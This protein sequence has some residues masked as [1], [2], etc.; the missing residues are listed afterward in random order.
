MEKYGQYR[1]KGSGI[2]PFFPISTERSGLYLPFHV[3]LF[4]IRVPLLIAVTVT[5][6]LLFSWLPVN[7]LVK[8]AA[9]WTIL[10]I[11]G[12]W[13]VDLQIDGVKRG[14][15][16]KHQNRLPRAGSL[17]A[18]SFT[19][20]VDCLYLAAIFDPVFTASYPSTRLVERISLFSAILRALRGPQLTPSKTARLVPLTTLFKENPDSSVVVLPECTTTNGRAILPFSTSLLTVP[21]KTKIYPVNLRYTPADITTPVPGA[22][23]SFLW[24][25]CSRPTHCIRV[26]IAE[27]IYSASASEVTSR[28]R[29]NTFESN[30]FDDMQMGGSMSSAETLVSNS[31]GGALT[32]EERK[33]IDHVAEDLARLGRVKRVGLGVVEK[34][35]FI[36]AWSKTRNIY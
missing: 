10:G 8:K 12:I 20:P 17:I 23:L 26:R 21:P 29:T 2:A 24:T 1:D 22:Y 9:L 31:D 16:A 33:V 27:A 5:Y 34:A 3:F 6:F 28:A 13:W 4:F 14:S 19:S 35:D 15:L 30:F 36:K 25:L 7:S 11:P 32:M 18:S